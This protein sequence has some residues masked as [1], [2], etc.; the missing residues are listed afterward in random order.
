MSND[1]LW[2]LVTSLSKSERGY[3]KK[4]SS[5]HQLGEENRYIALFDAIA[6]QSSYDEA[7]LRKQFKGEA[8]MNQFPAA[9]HYLYQAIMRSLRAFHRKGSV[10]MQVNETIMN[11]DILFRKGKF[12]LCRREIKK[13]KR[14]VREN[15][16]WDKFHE[17]TKWEKYLLGQQAEAMA[18]E[19]QTEALYKEDVEKARVLTNIM[20]Y[21]WLSHQ[22]Y[23]VSLKTGH[24]RQAS[25]VQQFEELLK[26]P[27]LQDESQALSVKALIFYHSIHAKYH[28]GAGNNEL[29]H[30]HNQRFVEVMEDNP[31]HLKNE[32]INYVSAVYNTLLSLSQLDRYDAFY[33][34]LKK[35]NQIPLDYPKQT[36]G[37]LATTLQFLAFNA[38]LYYLIRTHRFAECAPVLVRLDPALAKDSGKLYEL[39]YIEI[40]YYAAYAYFAMGEHRKALRFVNLIWQV[41]GGVL[42]AD[43]E[44]Y[45]RILSL[46]LHYELKNDELL[47]YHLRS[48]YRHFARKRKIPR[49]ERAILDFLQQQ[50]RSRTGTPLAPALRDVRTKLKR[51]ARSPLERN[52]FEH[53]DFIGWIDAQ[54][55]GVSFLETSTNRKD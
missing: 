10:T 51:I 45:T 34:N 2:E 19:R 47:F 21:S 12:D 54:L 20:E 15:E 24:I 32:L 7:A 11:I 50:L 49:W 14:L 37:R 55:S 17:I 27:L 42:R 26:H 22:I 48:A 52:A 18:N 8:F 4:Y 3:F 5:L 44:G 23:G 33:E 40:Y 29:F 46:V 31:G 39:Y 43:L 35:L 9:R 16:L 41:R 28:E 53:F 6:A 30:H 1:S 38:E 25:L 13:A 36:S